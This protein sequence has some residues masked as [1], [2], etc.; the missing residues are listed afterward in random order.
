MV[1]KEKVKDLEKQG[2]RL[3][4]N[5]SAIKVCLWTK[6]A[7]RN[8]DVCYKNTFYG[9]NSH[10]CVQMTP[11][12]HVCG[13]RC[14]W[15]WRDIS[16]TSSKWKGP[17]DEPK[18]IVDGCIL[19]HKK[20]LQGFRGNDK[21]DMGKFSES[22]IPLHFAISLSGEPASYPKLPGLIK[23]LRKREITSFLVTNGTSPSMVKKLVKEQPTQLYITLPAPDE[24][25]YVRVCS[26]LLKNQ[27]KKIIKSLKL[28][29]N[30]KRGTIRLTL[31]KDVN[32]VK[33]ERYAELI[34]L[35]KPKF[36]ECKAYMWVGYSRERLK[37]ENMPLHKDIKDFAK[38]LSKFSGYIIVDEKINSRVVLLA[39]NDVKDRIMKF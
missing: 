28:L 34:K 1:S 10:R 19:E 6:R 39:K 21:A 7:I 32:M 17:V 24:E 26:P 37:I 3:V 18:D 38:K 36:V 30:F 11:A 33:P 5:H 8:E 16:F 4:G 35:A 12:L 31:A 2:Y 13:N 14:V 25:T 29:K 15:C 22:L 23:E 20:Y 9:I 27:W